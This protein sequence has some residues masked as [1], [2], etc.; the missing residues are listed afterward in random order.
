MKTG[1]KPRDP[2]VAF[3]ERYIPE[4]NSGCW[5]WTGLLT[6]HGYGILPAGRRTR[7]RAHRF[8]LVL[9]T[10]WDPGSDVF[11]CHRCDNPPCVNPDHL[12]WGTLQENTADA[13]KKGRMH[14]RFQASKTHCRHG[15][16][17]SPDNTKIVNGSRVCIECSRARS[18]KHYAENAEKERA[19]KQVYY[20]DNMEKMRDRSLAYYHSHKE[21]K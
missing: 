15:H 8:S 14:N 20:Y 3:H 19:R 6:D 1:P 18:R 12:F 5:L 2:V 16:E 11:A 9:A 17:Y 21:S 4:P 13:A 10:G 7:I